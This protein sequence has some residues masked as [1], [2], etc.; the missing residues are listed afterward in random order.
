MMQSGIG[1]IWNLPNYAGELFTADTEQ[2]PFLSM[3][4]G[5]TGGMRT[6]NF[7]FP[8]NQLFDYPAPTQPA[9][10]ETDSTQA[11]T[12]KYTP[13]TQETNTVQIHQEAIE[14]SYWKMS[15][16]G[17]MSGLNTSGQTPSPSEDMGWQVTRGLTKIA[18]DVEHSFISGVYQQATSEAVA[19][20]T[21]GMMQVAG[22]ASTLAGAGAALS[23]DMLKTIYREMADNGAY[24][25]NMVCFVGSYQKQLLSEIYASQAGFNLPST[26]NIGGLDIREVETDFFKMGIVFS[27]YMPADAILIADVAHCAPV[28]M[29][30][31]GKGV[32]FVEEKEAPA[33]SQRRML[34]GQI[35]LDHGPAFL[36]ASITGLATA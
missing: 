5:M 3:I 19:A 9:I 20:K 36:H 17:R 29:E 18:R 31:P 21:R 35:G 27:R 24:F 22:T 2:T 10:S 13:R 30:V 12:P 15:N 6:R 28:F 8:T 25:D 7:E 26:R 4:G 33:A 1:T 16:G 34:Y 23:K 11:M 32:L 14:L